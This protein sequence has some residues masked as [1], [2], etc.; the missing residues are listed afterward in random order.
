MM[1]NRNTFGPVYEIQ[2]RTLWLLRS[3]NATT[4]LVWALKCKYAYITTAQ[5]KLTYKAKNVLT[6]EA[7][8]CNLKFQFENNNL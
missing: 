5:F 2:I 8:I 4:Q 1:P 6:F 7:Q 3:L